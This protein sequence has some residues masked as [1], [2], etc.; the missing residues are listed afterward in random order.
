LFSSGAGAHPLGFGFTDEPRGVVGEEEAGGDQVVGGYADSGDVG[1][2]GGVA[3]FQGRAVV[4]G[5]QAFGFGGGEG[6][7]GAEGA[8]GVGE[9]VGAVLVPAG[10]GADR[11]L[12]GDA[13]YAGEVVAVGVDLGDEDAVGGGADFGG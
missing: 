1:G 8:G 11:D 4:A 9:P 3:F 7:E 5:G 10:V 2:F 6:G 13:A 12:Q